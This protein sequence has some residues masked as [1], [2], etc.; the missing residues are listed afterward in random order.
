MVS[1]G[2]ESQP[3]EGKHAAQRGGGV[4]ISCVFCQCFWRPGL[5]STPVVSTSKPVVNASRSSS[6]TDQILLQLPPGR[7]SCCCLFLVLPPCLQPSLPPPL[8]ERPDAI[9]PTMGGQTGLNLAKNLA[10]SG[11][12]RY[13]L[14]KSSSSAAVIL[15][16][17][18]QAQPGGAA[19]PVHT[20]ARRLPSYFVLSQSCCN[21]QHQTSAQNHAICKEWYPVIQ[22]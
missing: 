12:Q 6:C 3:E 22:C 2:W 9:L 11:E 21:Q 7:L 18:P 20:S 10:E 19:P 4:S 15:P 17:Q 8:Q 13:L 16:A 1:C 5:D 14:N